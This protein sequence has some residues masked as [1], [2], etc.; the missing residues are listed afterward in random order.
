MEEGYVADYISIK[1]AEI[2]SP[3]FRPK[4]FNLVK[5]DS[6]RNTDSSIRSSPLLRS[7]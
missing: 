5:E 1:D 7:C 2:T 4:Y 6:L 3:N